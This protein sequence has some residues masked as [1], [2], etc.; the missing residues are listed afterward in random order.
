MKIDRNAL[1]RKICQLSFYEFVKE[2]WKVSIAEE[3]VWNWHIKFLC[4]ELQQ[5]AERVF[6]SEPKEHD[7]IINIPPGTT[8]STICSIMYPAWILTRMPSA[9]TICGSHTD[10]L[11]LDLSNK[12]RFIVQSAEYQAVFPYIKIREDQNTKGYWMTEQGGFRFSCTVGGKTPTGFHGHFLIVDD[13]ID[14]QKVLSEAEIKDANEWMANVI[15][16]RKVDSRVTVSLL[17]MQRL[18]QDDPT[19]NRLAKGDKA[20]KI[21]HI[22]LPAEKGPN[23]KPAYLKAKYKDGL[24]DGTRL[25][26]DVLGEKRESMGPFGYAGQYDQNPVPR[27]GGDFLTERIQ[28]G[29]PPG[30]FLRVVRYWDKA[31]THKGGARTA[32]VKLGIDKDKRIWILN[33]IKGQWGPHDR[34][35]VIV[36]TAKLDGKDVIIGIEQEPGSGG[37]ESAQA[38]AQR[39][40]GYRIRI[41]K[42]TGDKRTRAEPFAHQ[43][44][45]ENVWVPRGEEWLVQFLDEMHYFPNSKYKDQIDAASGAFATLTTK[46]LRYGAL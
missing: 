19:G 35:K 15:S 18:H 32:G 23:I 16:N 12:C 43:V 22:C 21:R 45:A 28:F 17:I 33:V 40:M 11:V 3:P 14:P 31:G 29:R 24:L 8:K 44:G 6:R 41:D 42:V 39:L 46:L 2:F 10:T 20:G 13:P 34:E 27:E 4:D 5:A 37:K 30:K 1:I 9:R 25:P 38:T 36:Q 7:Y 26:K